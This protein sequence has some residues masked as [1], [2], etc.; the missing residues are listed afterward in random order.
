C[1][2]R[3]AGVTSNRT[4]MIAFIMSYSR[5]K[6]ISRNRQRWA[7][8]AHNFASGVPQVENRS[9]LGNVTGFRFLECLPGI[10]AAGEIGDV[11]EAGTAKN[12]G[13]NRTPIAALAVHHEKPVAGNLCGSRSQLAQG[14]SQGVLHGSRF[15]LAALAYVENGDFFSLLIEQI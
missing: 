7:C 9:G 15:N 13:G 12:A 8:F 4:M 3:N 5:E 11:A 10:V 14:D 1:A 6:N 2:Q